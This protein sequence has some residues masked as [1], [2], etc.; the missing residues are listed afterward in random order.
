MKPQ[1]NIAVFTNQPSAVD[2][3]EA[4]EQSIRNKFLLVYSIAEDFKRII[5]RQLYKPEFASFNEY[6]DKYGW[7]EEMLDAV[8]R[9]KKLIDLL[10]ANG[11]CGHILAQNS[12]S[13]ELF[14][15]L[16]EREQVELARTVWKLAGDSKPT[17]E[18]IKKCK[19][20]LYPAKALV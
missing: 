5:D 2:E 7:C 9:V 11:I 17:V 13:F 6:A 20:Q 15:N 4:L 18:L 19:Q 3:L 16:D 10:A 1:Y 12:R 14:I 8:L